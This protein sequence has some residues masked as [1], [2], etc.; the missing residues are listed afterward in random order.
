VFLLQE[1]VEAN[2]K[3]LQ[4][5]TCYLFNVAA[6]A[7]MVSRGRKGSNMLSQSVAEVHSRLIGSILDQNRPGEREV[8]YTQEE[9]LAAGTLVLLSF[10]CAS[11]RIIVK[12][13]K[14]PLGK[15]ITPYTTRIFLDKYSFVAQ[16]LICYIAI[17]EIV[18]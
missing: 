9:N 10:G 3:V 17:L 18:L 1:K 7:E 15:N 5:H 4:R 2:R 6:A 8:V 13:V 14:V 12:F 11:Q 16:I